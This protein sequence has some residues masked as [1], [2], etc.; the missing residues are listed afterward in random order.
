MSEVKSNQDDSLL[1]PPPTASHSAFPAMAPRLPR[2][3]SPP[4]SPPAPSPCHPRSL[5]CTSLLSTWLGWY[6]VSGI[7]FS[8]VSGQS[9]PKVNMYQIRAE[10]VKQ[11]PS[12][13]E[14]WQ[15]QQA[16]GADDGAHPPSSLLHGQ[17]S[18]LMW[19][20]VTNSDLRSTT[21]HFL[22]T[23]RGDSSKEPITFH[24]HLHQ[25]LFMVPLQQ[26]DMLLPE[27]PNN[28]GW[29]PLSGQ[30]RDFALNLQLVLSNC[31]FP[32]SS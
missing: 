29:L 31:Y 28:P 19:T 32:S 13:S 12:C 26:L 7:L 5:H 15:G 4:A 2:S 14:G 23:H 6:H 10:T 21:R 30:V 17:L 24:W 3:W 11:Q 27:V 25:P 22:Q 18:F 20:L 8:V 16:A 9:W 1:K